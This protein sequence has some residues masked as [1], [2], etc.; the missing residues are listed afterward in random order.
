MA[1]DW[2]EWLSM[3]ET[4]EF[5]KRCEEAREQALSLLRGCA[6][7]DLYCR[8]DGIV[9]GMEVVLDLFDDLKKERRLV[10]G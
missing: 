3:E 2:S 5:K 10:D 7:F 8:H 6:S 4:R 9:K 1:V